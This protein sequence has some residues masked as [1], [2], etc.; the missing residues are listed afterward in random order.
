MS[1]KRR[2]PFPIFDEVDRIRLKV[3]KAV[4]EL[5][6]IADTSTDEG[7]AER[8]V[9]ALVDLGSLASVPLATVIE[10]IP[11]ARRRLRMVVSLRDI[12]PEFRL[13]VCFTLMR[14][15]QGDPSELVR[16]A[17]A[18]TSRILRKRSHEWFG[19]RAAREA[20]LQEDRLARREATAR[21]S[22]PTER[23][24]HGPVAQAGKRRTASESPCD[25]IPNRPGAVGS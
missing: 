21:V 2:T 15:K 24:S 3:Y 4:C 8:G 1:K 18:E 20:A 7:L 11:S 23:P 22:K 5:V 16:A 12:P 9:E 6:M 10:Q 13:D 25:P 17:A 19:R 14:L